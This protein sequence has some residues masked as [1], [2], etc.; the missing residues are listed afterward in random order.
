MVKRILN[1]SLA[2]KM[3]KNRLLC[4]FLPKMS[5]YRKGFDETKYMSFYDR[6][7]M[8]Y[9]KNIMKFGKKLKIVSKKIS[10][11]NLYTMKNI[12]KLKQNLVMEKSI[13]I[14]RIIK[15]QKKVLNL[16]VYQ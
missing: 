7:M 4:I 12:W 16:V 14:F 9:L 11:V 15:Y 2:T 10:I 6:K 1:I 5:A 8:N 3:L 13:N